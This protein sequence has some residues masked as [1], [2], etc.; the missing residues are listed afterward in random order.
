[1]YK[2]E[3]LIASSEDRITVDNDLREKKKQERLIREYREFW[4]K[5][6]GIPA[7]GWDLAIQAEAEEQAKERRDPEDDAAPITV[8]DIERMAKGQA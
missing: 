8:A 4:K 7:D 2:A 1:M 6:G 5:R 3:E